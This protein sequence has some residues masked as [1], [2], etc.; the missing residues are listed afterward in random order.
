[1][2]PFIF[3]ITVRPN[4]KPILGI[5]DKRFG[6]GSPAQM[7]W[8]NMLHK[9]IMPYVPFRTGTLAQSPAFG[10]PFGNGILIWRTPYAR[11]LYYNPQYNFT[12]ADLIPARGGRWVERAKNDKMNIWEAALQREVDAGR[13]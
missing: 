6:I 9:D 5:M 2:T 4:L 12:G 13:I 8:D 1:M 10:M 11:R 3:D 7:F